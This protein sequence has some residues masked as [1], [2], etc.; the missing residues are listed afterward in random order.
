[1]V[2]NKVGDKM[3]DIIEEL[4]SYKNE[5]EWFEFKENW[6]ELDKLGEYISAISNSA[7][8]CNKKEGYFIWGI[9]DKN[10][11]IV[12]TD[13]NIYQEYKNEPIQN[14]LARNLKPSINFRFEELNIKDKRVVILIIPS[15][16]DIPTSYKEK[17]FIRIGSSKVNLNAYPKREKDLF[18]ILE[19]GI[20]T[21]ENTCSKYQ[22]LTFS[23]LFGYYGSK[24]IILNEKTFKRNL[25]L[26]TEDGKYNILAQIL[27]DNSRLPL[28]V[29]IFEG[30]NKA[31][32][33]FSVRD[34]GFNCILYSLEELLRY[35]DVLNIIQTDEKDRVV[36]R[37]EIPLFDNEV[38]REVIIN[39]ILH[40]KWVEENEP[41]IT[42]YKDR[43]EILSRGYLAPTQTLNGFFKGEFI[44]V[45]S[46]LSEI[47]LQLH[48]SEKS[49]R[50]VPK[51]VEK[52]GK[53]VFDFRENSIVVTLPFNW[54]SERKDNLKDIKLSENRKNIILEM[55]N[56]PNITKEELTKIIGISSTAIDKN[57]SYLKT[58]GF[59]TRVGSNKNGYWKVLENEK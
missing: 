15:A 4:C 22:D 8:I 39:A 46:K 56:N 58:Q 55:R 51:I 38:F 35:G 44:P 37:K 17:R 30:N 11:N 57:I 18:K 52:Y 26:L 19:S 16:T 45:N 42:V 41:M 1:M 20:P 12:G 5:R 21:I 50:G 9:N 32:K 43:I 54:I 40:N 47:F 25:N 29:S 7:A 13:F 27:S 48:I 14:Y 23:K 53:E 49:G 3:K 33:L 36:E 28:R 2:G 34:F 6:F 59:I 31:S 10:H 24:G